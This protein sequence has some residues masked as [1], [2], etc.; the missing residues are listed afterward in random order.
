MSLG[1]MWPIT[2][3]AVGWAGSVNSNFQTLDG[4]T[5]AQ[6]LGNGNT[7]GA[8]NVIVSAS[9]NIQWATGGTFSAS[10]PEI[11]GPTDT[12]LYVTAGTPTGS[13]SGNPLQITAGAGNTAGAGGLASLV[14]GASAGAD[15]AAGGVTIDAGNSTGGGNQTILFNAP[16][17]AAPGSSTPNTSGT[18]AKFARST[19]V[20]GTNN[21][22]YNFVVNATGAVLDQGA[23]DGFLCIPRCATGAPSGTP[24]AYT[25]TGALVIGGDHHL[26]A[27][28]TAGSWSQ[29]D[30]A[31]SAG[32]LSQTLGNGNTTGGHH[33]VVTTGDGVA[34]NSGTPVANSIQFGTGGGA[35]TAHIQGP[36]D[37]DFALVAGSGKNLVLK[38][39][40][41]SKGTPAVQI[42]QGSLTEVVG[43]VFDRQA[44][45]VTVTNTTTETSVYSVS[46]PGNTLGTTGRIRV[47]LCA[48]YQVTSG[49]P[50]FTIR[51]Y[52]G[53]S[54]YI[55]GAPTLQSSANN[56]TPFSIDLTLSA[57]NATN[58]QSILANTFYG[59]TP[60]YGS[61]NG[62]IGFGLPAIDSTA[63]QTLKITVQW[64]TA[65]TTNIF[66]ADHVM[67]EFMQ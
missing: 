54:G 50:T 9:K 53:A 31:G 67:S 12:G 18:I 39:N 51:A 1:L 49:T 36:T 11:L 59:S 2:E 34:F 7:T 60:N 45:S 5:L 21:K 47:R 43:G 62:L 42:V 58:A 17:V 40:G 15:K 38:P 66:V 57:L 6:V 30:G 52:Y 25:G 10:V 4:I 20:A 56:Q 48:H 32:T 8:N 28:L 13:A 24:T 35:V 19:T 33:V 37:Q 3:G 65:S 41:G 14:G 16:P 61:A 63:A 29:V 23:V 26:Y 27:E 55:V 64:G 44:T 22:P 46:V